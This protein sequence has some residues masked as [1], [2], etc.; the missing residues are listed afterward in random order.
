MYEPRYSRIEIPIVQR[1]FPASSI[2]RRSIK[3]SLIALRALQRVSGSR[4]PFDRSFE[5]ETCMS[6]I[7]AR[8]SDEG[9][10]FPAEQV[11]AFYLTVQIAHLKER[12]RKHRDCRKRCILA[13]LDC[14]I[15]LTNVQ[16]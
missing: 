9:N 15:R 10:G 6:R 14:N 12:Y 2:D 13:T 7:A 4:A 8:N 11:I 16:L 5:C 1:H 3:H